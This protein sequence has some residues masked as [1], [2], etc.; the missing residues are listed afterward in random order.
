MKDRTLKILQILVQDFIET[1]KPIASKRLLESHIDLNVSSATIRNEFAL[2][3]EVGLIES[4]HISSGKVP[5]EKGF[6]FFVDEFLDS[7]EEEQEKLVA[8]LFEKQ[9]GAYKFYKSKESVLDTLRVISQLTMNVAFVYLDNDKTSYIGLSNVL[10]SPEYLQEPEKAAQIIEILEGQARFKDLL[11]KLDLPEKEVKIFIGEENLLEE[12][13][14]CAMLATRFS[15]KDIS[16]V[17]GILGPMRMKYAFNK[18]VLRNS[19]SMIY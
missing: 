16:G 18:A 1:A 5:T 12:I 17:L 11:L 14:S 7:R 6:R 3:E 19:L 9:I 13:S 15:T 4:Q 2:L 10:R 8:N